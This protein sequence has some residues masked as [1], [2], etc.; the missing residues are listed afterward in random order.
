ALECLAEDGPL[1]LTE[2]AHHF[3]AGADGPGDER[4][5]GYTLQA[6][7][8]ASDVLAHEQAAGLYERARE[9]IAAP[10]T[11]ADSRQ[12]DVLLLTG[13]AY[14]RAGDTARARG[15]F[16][17]AFRLADALDDPK[18]LGRA[19]LG[20]G[21][22][23][24]V[25]DLDEELVALLRRALDRLGEGH[26][27]LAARL[28]ARLAQA[29]YFT[30]GPAERS[31]LSRRAVKE[32][33]SC[34]D[35]GAL[36]SVLCAR[37]AALWG[38][39]DVGERLEVANEVLHLAG[40]THSVELELQGHAW[41]L[42][43]LL[44]LGDSGGA[45]E[46]MAAHAEL[47]ARLNQPRH[48][49]DAAAWRTMRAMLGGRFDEAEEAL[50]DVFALSDRAD[51]PEATIA[52]CQRWWLVSERGNREE[53]ARITQRIRELAE[54]QGPSRPAWLAGLALHDAR[55]G[56][57]EAAQHVVEELVDH[58]LRALP[59]NAVWLNTL[60]HLADTVAL[61][62]DE[63]RAVALYDLLGPYSDR[64]AL[65]D[66]AIV[67]KGSVSHY[68]GLLARTMGDTAGAARHFDAALATYRRI[69]AAPLAARTERE[70]ALT[71][72]G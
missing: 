23:A 20:V 64:M 36:A 16:V 28:L 52:W 65:L 59:R 72:A 26:G 61:L 44:E 32:A 1:R 43:D 15:I 34:G 8:S 50:E 25:W 62:G 5:I 14:R 24:P 49:R 57:G 60:T 47:A 53:M 71:G 70:A 40:A 68:L 41:R 63:P 21:D 3:A 38:P 37:H 17:D 58:D 56:A 69:G 2:L 27:P 67:C 6:A 42:V 7:Q 33:R 13:D 48:Q 18:R 54:R 9:L 10:G 22:S 35:T 12:L 4:A 51:D 30:A 29:L 55:L 31:E 11:V 45:D 66:R 19:A 39:D 46:A